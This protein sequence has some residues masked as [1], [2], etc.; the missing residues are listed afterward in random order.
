MARTRATESASAV[1]MRAGDGFVSVNDRSRGVWTVAR[2]ARGG[3]AR[4]N[5]TAACDCETAMMITTF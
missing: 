3:D 2:D 5:A 4:E 1:K